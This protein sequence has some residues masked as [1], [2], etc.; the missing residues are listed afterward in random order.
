MRNSKSME[1][2]RKI[3]E[4]KSKLQNHNVELQMLHLRLTMEVNLRLMIYT[5]LHLETWNPAS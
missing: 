4:K 3:D 5:F 1:N 2:D